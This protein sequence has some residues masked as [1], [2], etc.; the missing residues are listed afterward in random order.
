[1]I[2]KSFK[3][4]FEKEIEKKISEVIKREQITTAP[5]ISAT[6]KISIP[7]V[8]TY[9]KKMEKKGKV[10]KKILKMNQIVWF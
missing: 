4:Q 10:R 1:M 3:K 6:L 5:I 7:T 9:L 8:L 2:A